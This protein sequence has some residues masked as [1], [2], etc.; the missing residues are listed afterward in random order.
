MLPQTMSIFDFIPIVPPAAPGE[1]SSELEPSQRFVAGATSTIFP[2]I[3][4]VLA[5]FTGFASH[6]AVA[7]V[8]LPVTAAALTYLIARWVSTPIAWA[9]VLA[10]STA[11]FC[12]VGDGCALFLGALGRFYQEF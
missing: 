3:S 4:F 8:A 12:F 2:T 1:R 11:G 9:I 10:M 7:L 6:V 5:L